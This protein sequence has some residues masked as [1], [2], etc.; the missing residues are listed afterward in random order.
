M[1]YEI[2]MD[3][4]QECDCGRGT[5]RYVFEMD[6]WNRT[7]SHTEVFCNFCN[8]QTRIKTDIRS[9]Q[10]NRE[11]ELTEYAYDYFMNNYYAM[12]Y[13]FV[14]KYKTK[15]DRYVYLKSM[16]LLTLYIGVNEQD[17]FIRKHKKDDIAY[18]CVFPENYVKILSILSINDMDYIDKVNELV[19]LK[20]ISDGIRY[21]K[22]YRAA[23]FK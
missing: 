3:E 20:S 6:D 4:I 10:V 16:D 13:D 21:N 15:K 18:A 8:E 12:W 14:N 17:A 11:R 9:V 22:M 5:Q 19:E 1:S 7:R 23:R 2:M